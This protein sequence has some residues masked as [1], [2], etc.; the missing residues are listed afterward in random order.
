[1]GRPPVKPS[2]P[3]KRLKHVIRPMAPRISLKRLKEVARPSSKPDVP[4][5]PFLA[6]LKREVFKEKKRGGEERKRTEQ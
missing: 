1:M 4:S 3:L 6:C 2:I 5:E